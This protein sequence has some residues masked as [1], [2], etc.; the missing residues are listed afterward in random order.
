M[1][2]A[3]R[4]RL[5]DEADYLT[6][7]RDADIRH[8][9]VDGVL[10]AM[11]GAS[12]AHNLLATGLSS[13][14]YVHLRGSGCRVSS[15]DMKVRLDGGRR[16]YYP[17]LVVSCSDVRDEPDDYTETRPVLVVEIL[18]PATAATDRREKRLAYQ[19]IPSLIDYLIVSQ[20]E[21]GAVRYSR[22]GEAWTEAT[23]GAGETIELASVELAL[24]MDD[25]YA[26]VPLAGTSAE[27]PDGD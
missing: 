17:D 12:R 16:Y 1:G 14:L 24:A 7:E 10:F 27:A 26:D 9:Y 15:S 13:A 5:V 19:T 11:T 4:Q 8:E 6:A 3:V 21:R 25:L 2:T 22:D 18:S 23:F 20:E